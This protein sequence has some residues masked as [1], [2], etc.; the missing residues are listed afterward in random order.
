MQKKLCLCPC[1]SRWLAKQFWRR[2]SLLFSLSCVKPS[3]MFLSKINCLK[4]VRDCYRTA[5]RPIHELF[6]ILFVEFCRLSAWL[7]GG[8]SALREPFS[9]YRLL[10]HILHSRCKCPKRLQQIFDLND[11]QKK[12]C[13]CRKCWFFSTW[14]YNFLVLKKYLVNY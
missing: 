7:R 5:F 14:I 12:Q 9:R 3:T 1:V 8:I 6:G 13:R 4:I 11:K 10:K 2:S